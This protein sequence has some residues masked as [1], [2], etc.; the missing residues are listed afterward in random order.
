MKESVKIDAALVDKVRR[1]VKKTKQTIGG[2]FEAAA[3]SSLV[4]KTST[5][6]NCDAFE[7]FLT[8]R[9]ITWKNNGHYTTIFGVSD[10]IGLGV[11]YGEY[12][13]KHKPERQ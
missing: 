1:R 12:R 9:G 11:E 10:P 2:F 7:N 13:A 3:E 5:P 4:I 8:E 6:D